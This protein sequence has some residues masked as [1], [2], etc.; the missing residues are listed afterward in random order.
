[1]TFS[2]IV[3][4]EP[5]LDNYRWVRNQ[6]R[7]ITGGKLRYV[8]SYQSVVLYD[9][10]ED[11]HAVAAQI[12]DALTGVATPVIRVIPVDYV[13]EPEVEEV[14]EVV[15]EFIAPKIPGGVK[16]RVSL[17]GHLLGR[18]EDGR[19][20]RMHTLDSVRRVAALIDRPVDLER[21]DVVVFIKVV[22]Y[23]R[24][25]RKAAVSLLKPEELKRV[26]P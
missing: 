23:M 15:K 20:R 17:E 18:G 11:P 3:T 21:P 13:T 4:H 19:L 12:R 1:M 8:S 2:L 5:G 26:S 7:Q 14:C 6:L 16:F 24:W 9:V 10:D 22:R 25:R